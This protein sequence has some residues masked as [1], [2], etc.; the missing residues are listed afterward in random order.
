MDP[1][2]DRISRHLLSRIH[3]LS[4]LDLY[5]RASDIGLLA[6]NFP[7]GEKKWAIV[8]QVSAAAASGLAGDGDRARRLIGR[9]LKR[10][11][12]TLHDG[13][14]LSREFPC[15]G[16]FTTSAQTGLSLRITPTAAIRKSRDRKCNRGQM[17][18]SEPTLHVPAASPWRHPSVNLWNDGGNRY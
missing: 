2:A 7:F 9:A 18:R 12:T 13:L 5:Q 15:P 14:N 4:V 16:F 17:D 11:P 3:R 10:A 8:W 1:I 6:I